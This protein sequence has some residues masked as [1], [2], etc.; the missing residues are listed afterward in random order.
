VEVEEVVQQQVSVDMVV[1]LVVLVL[2]EAEVAQVLQEVA[3]GEAAMEWWLLSV[4]R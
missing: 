3:E 1:T 4:G 2:V